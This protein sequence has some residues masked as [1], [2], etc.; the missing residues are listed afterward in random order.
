MKGICSLIPWALFWCWQN[1]VSV[2]V[3]C[4]HEFIETRGSLNL[5]YSDRSCIW[6]PCSIGLLYCDCLILRRWKRDLPRDRHALSMHV[7]Y[8]AH[9]MNYS[10]ASFRWSLSPI[11]RQ[12]TVRRKRPLENKAWQLLLILSNISNFF[13]FYLFIGCDWDMT[14]YLLK[15]KIYIV[16]LIPTLFL[17]SLEHNLWNH[18]LG[19]FLVSQKK[20]KKIKSKPIAGR[21]VL[22]DP[23]TVQKTLHN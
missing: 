8:K 13:N 17:L 23:Q 18:F 16:F 19:N 4:S 15:F 3:H 21:H 5:C 22:V 2:N 9:H 12:Q 7:A 6:S 11:I 1:I 10:Q 20:R 14:W